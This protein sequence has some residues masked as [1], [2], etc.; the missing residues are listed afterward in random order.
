MKA[1][2]QL[3]LG[4]CLGQLA[5]D[6]YTGAI[7]SSLHAASSSLSPVALLEANPAQ[8]GFFGTAL[9]IRLDM[10]YLALPSAPA[11]KPPCTSPPPNSAHT[12]FFTPILRLPNP[13]LWRLYAGYS[14]H[15]V[16]NWVAPLTLIEL[17]TYGIDTDMPALHT[18]S[19]TLIT[20]TESL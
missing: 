3:L 1:L 4:L 18:L 17:Y 5:A 2:K 12:C 6:M 7:A 20:S 9:P 11:C 19:L 16:P 15:L 8:A 14:Y 13:A 10:Q